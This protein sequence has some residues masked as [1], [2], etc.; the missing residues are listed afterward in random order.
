MTRLLREKAV[1]VNCKDN[2]GYTPLMICSK[3]DQQSPPS[4]TG[5]ADNKLAA[6]KLLI[7]SDCDVTMK[8]AEDRTAL[9][10]VCNTY[11]TQASLAALQVL[12]EAGLRLDQ[13]DW[14]GVSGFEWLIWSNRLVPIE[15]DVSDVTR[16]EIT[17][18]HTPLDLDLPMISNLGVESSNSGPSEDGYS[19]SEEAEEEESFEV[20]REEFW[21]FWN[22]RIVF[23]IEHMD[24]DQLQFP[25]TTGRHP[26]GY[27]IQYA[28]PNT[29]M[30]LLE[31]GVDVDAI[32]TD[33]RGFAPLDFA[34]E[35]GCSTE[36]A[37]SI[38]SKTRRPIDAFTGG[39]KNNPLHICS[40]KPKGSMALLP[41]LLIAHADP[42]LPNLGG[43]TPLMLAAKAKAVAPLKFFLKLKVNL[44]TRVNGYGATALHI[45]VELGF[46]EA[47]SSLLDAGAELESL[48]A[49]DLT[50]IQVASKAHR[51]NTFKLLSQAG[52]STAVKMHQGSSILHE[53]AAG[54]AEEILKLILNQQSTLDVDLRD[55]G[56][57]TA[58]HR[59]AT[60]GNAHCVQ[61]LLEKGASLSS[62][63]VWGN[64]AHFAM[65]SPSDGVRKALLGKAIDWGGKGTTQF[66]T[67]RVVNLLPLHVAAIEGCLAAIHFLNDNGF[68]ADINAPAGWRLTPLHLA[69]LRNKCNALSLLLRLGA[70]INAIESRVGQTALHIAARLGHAETVSLL[71][72]RGCDPN[73]L[74][75]N[76]ST[77]E[78][79]AH[80]WDH[81]R[82]I[83]A[84]KHHLSNDSTI[85]QALTKNPPGDFRP[86]PKFTA[87]WKLPLKYGALF[88]RVLRGDVLLFAVD[89][90]MCQPQ[91]LETLAEYRGTG[92][93]CIDEA[94]LGDDNA[95]DTLTK[96]MKQE[97]DNTNEKPHQITV[98]TAGS[99]S[100]WFRAQSSMASSDWY[101]Q[102]IIAGMTRL[103]TLLIAIWIVIWLRELRADLLDLRATG[104]LVR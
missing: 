45:A 40:T 91:I 90:R 70:E 7:E 81:R 94:S 15:E 58:L 44:N 75:A 59:A 50:P 20:I 51:W 102:P 54:G 18:E 85:E 79:L 74:D 80:K 28:T 21:D 86:P 42:E 8:N 43:Y 19:E 60:S 2:D 99:W 46:N 30:R 93:E 12:T 29:T 55:A 48:G 64:I 3:L 11:P 101:N 5:D 71:L 89:K 88:Q 100:T 1:D 6:I 61:I 104:S 37:Q 10:Y 36:V 49:S 47:V 17:V 56:G 13:K 87:S 38:V 53:A 22:R 73:I 96:D 95:N 67:I 84:F 82:I 34:A 97:S 35:F 72:E 23:C 26:L 14:Q 52:A 25:L 65:V 24:V 83:Q 66:G 41:Q 32:D 98:K 4:W 68:I 63:S 16:S 62:T 27:L 39:N 78:V 33:E 103:G 76:E 9:H 92:I 31:K 69:A 57:P 77:A